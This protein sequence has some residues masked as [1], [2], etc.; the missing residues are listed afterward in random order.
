M[1]RRRRI[2]HRN[3]G[4][5]SSGG[6]RVEYLRG[7][8]SGGADGE[9][10]RG[11]PQGPAEKTDK[12]GGPGAETPAA[13]PLAAGG[14]ADVLREPPVVIEDWAERRAEGILRGMRARG[15]K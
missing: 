5:E 7:A 1:G 13:D 3:R 15:I 10:T 4:G 14:R 11:V 8:E 2:R 12:H 9:R 6:V